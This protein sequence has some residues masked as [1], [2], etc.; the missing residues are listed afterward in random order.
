MKKTLAAVAAAGFAATTLVAGT[1]Y[2]AEVEGTVESVD[3]TTRTI[4]LD[5]GTT[6]TAEASV[7][8]E[9]L[10]EGD[11]VTVEVDDTTTS[12]TSVETK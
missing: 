10:S 12:A 5:D 4:T 3:P 1:A 8:L 2:A 9:S 7:D 6:Y 11:Q